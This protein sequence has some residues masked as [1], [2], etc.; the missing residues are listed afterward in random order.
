MPAWA[1]AIWLL[2]YYGHIVLAFDEHGSL[3]GWFGVL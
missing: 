2:C 1:C 3:A